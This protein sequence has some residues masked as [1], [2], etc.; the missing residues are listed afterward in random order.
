MIPTIIPS[1]VEVVKWMDVEGMNQQ[2]P[3]TS[4]GLSSKILL[5]QFAWLIVQS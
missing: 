2:P 4:K 1:M 3:S 5:K